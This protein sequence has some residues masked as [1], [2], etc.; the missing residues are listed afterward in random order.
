MPPPDTSLH[1]GQQARA[2]KVSA[3]SGATLG[4]VG[5]DQGRFVL[6]HLS[7]RILNLLTHVIRKQ[8]LRT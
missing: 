5:Y 2:V 8:T 7:P 4:L 3:S 6:A 1:V